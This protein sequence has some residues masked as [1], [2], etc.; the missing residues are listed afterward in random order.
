[1]RDELDLSVVIPALNEGPNLAILL[2]QLAGILDSLGIS[3]E[4]IVVTTARDDDT[5]KA[6]VNAGAIVIEQRAPGY[7]SA[8]REGFQSARGRF[9]LTMDADLSHPPTFVA[10]MW[11]ARHSAEITIASRYVPGGRATMPRARLILSRILNTWFGR[12]LSV[13]LRDLSSGFRLYRRHVLQLDKYSGTDFDLLQEIVV[14][15]Y[16]EGWRVQ[17][18]PFEYMPRRHGTSSARVMRVG[19]AYLK[20]FVP[21]WKLRNSIEAADYDDRGFDSPIPLQRYWQRKRF[22][23]ATELI[24]GEGPVLD[25]G[26]GSSRIISAL[27]PGSV[28]LDVLVRKLRY[29]RKFSTP[30]VHGSGYALPFPDD[31]FSCVLSSEVI[32]H[33]P[34]DSPMID[35]LCRVLA[36]GGRLVLGTPDYS[37]WEW[38]YLEKAYAKFAPGGYADEHIAHY[39]RDELLAMFAAR[40]FEHEATRYIMRGELILAFRK[41]VTIDLR[42]QTRPEVVATLPNPA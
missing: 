21:L 37:R 27:P 17:E 29:A 42:T 19:R 5:R 40:G 24:D 16:C 11:R 12:G 28:A 4:T 18:I 30:V 41:P 15:A 22:A 34:K 20:T 33:I 8:T 13:P 2:P 7:G 39:T 6:A 25:V 35:E 23:F 38:V 26:C 31:S 36:P 9:V 32:E 14:R 3:H 1:M 10:D